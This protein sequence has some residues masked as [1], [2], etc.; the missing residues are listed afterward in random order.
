MF[1]TVSNA[2][3]LERDRW[4]LWLPVFYAVGIS[5]Y[6]G[7]PMEPP[8]AA[9]LMPAV[10]AAALAVVWRHGILA[11]PLT[12]ILVAVTF[13][14]AS[15]KLRTEWV[16]APVLQTS[17]KR[18]DLSGFVVRVEPRATRG[19]RVTIAV[20]TLGRLEPE[21]RP[22]RV[23]IR[24]RR[25]MPG[26]V[27]GQ[28]VKVR[29]TLAPPAIPALPG[30]FDFAR[31]AFFQRIGAVGFAADEPAAAP[32]LGAPDLALRISAWLER[33]RQE[34]GT[35]ITSAL[36]GETGAL[37]NALMTG[38]RGQVS[39]ATLDAYRNSGLLHIL[40]IS[41]LHMAIMA[42][43]VFFFLRLML[44]ALPA[45]ALHFPIKKWAAAA[46]AVAALAYLLISG[47]S[48]ATIRAFIMILIMLLA[49][50]LDRPA[51]ALRNV[52]VAALLILVFIP[53]SLFNVGFQMSFAAV[54]ALVA[55]YEAW[56][57]RRRALPRDGPLPRG[58]FGYGRWF[59]L[60]FLG[61]AMS[62][63]I[64]GLAVAP[65]SVFH[66]HQSQQLSVLANMIAVP[67]CNFVVM[68]AALMSFIAMPFGLE[69][70]PLWLMGQGIDVMTWTARRVAELPGAVSHIPVIPTH[71]FALV[72]F[73]G[74]W[75]FIWRTRRRLLGLAAIALGIAL[76]PFAP[77]PDALVG[78]DGWLVAVRKPDGRLAALQ[79]R[80]GQFELHRW[81]Q[82]DGDGRAVK[83]AADAAAYR[84]DQSGCV[85]RVKS[86]VFAVARHP[87]ALADDC[88][89]A[90][91]LVLRFPKPRGCRPNGTTIDVSALRRG[92]THAVFIDKDG[93]V[94]I[95]T[96]AERRGLRP[97]SQ[98]PLRQRQPP[99]KRR[100][101]SRRLEHFAAPA[102][103]E[104][105]GEERWRPEVEGDDPFGWND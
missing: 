85:A 28:P 66:F 36:S 27:P 69:V 9:A 70:F 79:N 19:P 26:L 29:A 38:E 71:A 17:L 42:G 68:P 32:E 104:R 16:R 47:G 81:L 48:F 2:V 53:E 23:R 20:R 46:A 31:T 76:A 5:I 98:R 37:A 25:P 74:L 72:V 99:G 8:V 52:A 22:R 51:I 67:V 21:A 95:T 49:V 78:R 88:R 35:R 58:G 10:A 1:D 86:V 18:V 92:G 96:V 39:Q 15:A 93:K 90:G 103:L 14:I 62:T 12:G 83:D 75:L 60:F 65:F 84:C 50:L 24:L 30:G 89:R 11:I 13:G 45:L 59:V 101:G 54:A 3:M 33:R 43:S 34:I 44:A 56:R 40:A 87:S 63:T 91:V 80:G 82:S 77:R 61:V 105:A 55:G 97:W 4:F 7:L 57:D 100:A 94:H 64:A 41:G 73:G 102:P 6:M